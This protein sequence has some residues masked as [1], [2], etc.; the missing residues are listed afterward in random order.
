VATCEFW[1]P[2][3]SETLAK[4]PELDP[5]AILALRDRAL[6]TSPAALVAISREA[7]RGLNTNSPLGRLT[8][9]LLDLYSSISRATD[10]RVLIDSSK[11][12]GD[13]YMIA[14]LTDIELY[15]LHLVR[16]PRATAHSWSRRKLAFYDPPVYFAQ[17]SP[18]ESS[19][20][21]LRRNAVVEACVRP[22]L[23]DRYMRMRYEDFAARPREAAQSICA[24]MGEPDASLPF[25]GDRRIRIQPSHT[26]SGNPV[27]FTERE[28]EIRPDDEWRAQMGRRARL[29]AMLPAAPLMPRYGYPVLSGNGGHAATRSDS[30]PP[31]SSHGPARRAV[32]R[33]LPGWIKPRL[34][35]LRGQYPPRPLSVPASYLRTRIPVPPP[36]ISIVTPSL[37]HGRYIESTIGSILGQGYPRLEY[38]VMDGGSSDGTVEILERHR[39]RLHHLESAP[40]NGQAAAINR[41]FGHTS[42]EIMGW[43]NSD[44]LLLPG[45][46]A[47]VAEVFDKHPEVDVIYGHRILI[48]EDGRDIGLWVTPP[49]T[50]DSLRWF[51]YLPQETAFWRRALWERTGGIDESFGVAFDWD[52]FLRFQESGA[53]IRRV[54]RFLG[55]FRL[56]PGQRTRVHHDSAQD[57]LAS[58]RERWNGRHVG[59]DEARSQVDRLRVRSLPHYAWH[60]W[61]SRMPIKRVPVRPS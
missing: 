39:H 20:H 58:I 50:V 47:H 19:I 25:T 60:R 42:G 28:L 6:T 12:A 29:L 34:G 31:P 55:G 24:F 21:W 2:I 46:L 8:S 37:D 40:D 49:H 27:R 15:V 32:G 52:L 13:A 41:G 10:A 11:S 17:L 4:H 44:D 54:P 30:Q 26:A 45:S 35:E 23:G 3:L 56:H 1:K 51:D 48:D 61:A 18:Q 5:E 53:Q 59:L 9:V 7:R 38:V 33:A 16:D 36:S 22:R 43:V 57:E 14:A